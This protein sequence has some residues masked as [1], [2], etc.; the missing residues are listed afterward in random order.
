MENENEIDHVEHI[1]SIIEQLTNNKYA[2][3]GDEVRDTYSEYYTNFKTEFL[4]SSKN[5]NESNVE[6]IKS[7]YT[8]SLQLLATSLQ[9]LEHAY[10]IILCIKHVSEDLNI[11]FNDLTKDSMLISDTFVQNIVDNIKSDLSSDLTELLIKYKENDY[12][13]N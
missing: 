5:N 8:I 4:K 10:K 6:L 13:Q 7:S 11:Q 3:L 9:E 2:T 12:E 1:N